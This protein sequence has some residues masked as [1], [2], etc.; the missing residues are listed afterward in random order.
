M[1]DLNSPY[2]RYNVACTISAKPDYESVVSRRIS[3]V[4]RTGPSLSEKKISDSNKLDLSNFVAYKPAADEIT[5]MVEF[6]LA[7]AQDPSYEGV[8][9]DTP[10]S[11]PAHRF[12]T[13]LK[14]SSV[15]VRWIDTD[16]SRKHD[17]LLLLAGAVIAFGAAIVLEIGK[18]LMPLERA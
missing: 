7:D 12:K 4:G 3:F 2:T 1:L 8:P 15:S 11:G 14:N 5:K 10:N 17:L 18:I 6:V 13:T 16:A 9:A